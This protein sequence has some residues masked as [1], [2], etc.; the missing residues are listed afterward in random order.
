MQGAEMNPPGDFMIVLPSK[1]NEI[2]N[3]TF[4]SDDKSVEWRNVAA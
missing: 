4:L 1:Q 2:R 3:T